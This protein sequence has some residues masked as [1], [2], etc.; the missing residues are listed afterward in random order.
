[1]SPLLFFSFPPPETRRCCKGYWRPRGTSI[2]SS[3]PDREN[4][5]QR[6]SSTAKRSASYNNGKRSIRRAMQPLS[7]R[8]N[9][10]KK[11]AGSWRSM[12]HANEWSGPQS[13]GGS[14]QEQRSP[15]CSIQ[16]EFMNG[17]GIIVNC[18]SLLF[19]GRATTGRVRNQNTR[20][21]S[22]E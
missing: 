11:K 3:K 7:K 19:P 14:L 20:S 2:N 16:T 10:L 8:L 18:D 9:T 17:A 15:T 22:L 13:R 1:M 6:L 5:R 21:R 12:W 4:K